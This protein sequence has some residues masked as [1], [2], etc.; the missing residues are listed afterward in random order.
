MTIT[1]TAAVATRVARPM[2]IATA[3]ITAIHSAATYAARGS[4]GYHDAYG[5]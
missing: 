5:S 3:A 4:S 1:A 2:V